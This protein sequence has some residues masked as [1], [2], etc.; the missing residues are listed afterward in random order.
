MIEPMNILASRQH[1]AVCLV[2]P[3]RSGKTLGLLDA[4]FTYAVT[5]DPGDMLIVQMTQDKARDYSKTRIDRAIRY[6]PA[7]KKL[8]SARGHDDNTHDKIFRHGMWA[9][10]GWPSASQLASTDYRYV[11]LTDYDRMPDDVDGEG[12]PFQLGLKRTTTFLSRGMCMVESSPGRTLND[13]G[14]Q[15]ATPH[16]GPPCGGIIGIYNRGDRR[17]LYWPCPH[18]GE[19]HEASPGLKLFASL[20]EEAELLTIVREYDLSK[21]AREHAV[22]FCPHCGAGTTAEHKQRMLEAGQWLRDGQQIDR[23]GNK[24]GEGIQSSI[25]SYWLGGV[26]AAYQKWESLILRYLQGLRDYAASGDE[27][28]LRTTLNTDQAMPYLPRA[29]QDE[30]KRANVAE[31]AEAFPRFIVPEAAR[32]LTAAVDVQGGQNARF[33]VQVHAHGPSMEQWLIDRYDIR[34][35]KRQ[36]APIDPALYP[37]D[38]DILTER[39]VK[40]TYK[41]HIEGQ[42]LRTLLTVVDSGGEAGVTENAYAW[43]RRVRKSGISD[44]VRL[45]KGG[46]TPSAPLLRLTRV[47][48]RFKDIPLLLCNPNLLKDAVFNAARRVG[49]GSSSL[50]FPRWLGAAFWD[51]FKAEV[52]EPK[53]KWKKIRKRNEALDLA[54]MNRAASL[55]LG[56]DRLNW[57]NPP[58]WARPCDT[59]SERMTREERRAMQ[60]KSSTPPKNR[61]QYGSDEWNNRL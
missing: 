2:G 12:S 59:N 17:R 36:G 58:A 43:Y 11:A 30:A 38:W 48:G 60:A 50:H 37:E 31:L 49:G 10:I 16:E 7:L 52:R 22:I 23:H 29:L 14:W 8:I 56:A 9:K 55:S 5:C 4:W 39:V 13:P 40:S 32:Y 53:G 57:D 46:S 47:G 61:P 42:E 24:S 28:T 26:A 45:Y 33:V 54:C 20:P 19:Y 27:H 21:M 18:C 6:S 1:E 3:A 15:P 35:S 41:T 44:R 25:A 34:E 51:E